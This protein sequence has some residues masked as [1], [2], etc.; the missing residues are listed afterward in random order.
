MQRWPAHPAIDAT[1]FD[2]VMSG[3]ASGITIR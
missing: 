2:A 3:C 1:T